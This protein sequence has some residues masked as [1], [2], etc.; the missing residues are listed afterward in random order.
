MACICTTTHPCHPVSWDWH[1]RRKAQSASSPS[2]DRSPIITTWYPFLIEWSRRH[3]VQCPSPGE[4][5]FLGALGG[6]GAQCPH[7]SITLF[8]PCGHSSFFAGPGVRA[9]CLRHTISVEGLR[10]KACVGFMLSL[11]LSP[12]ESG[13]PGETNVR[14]VAVLI[15]THRAA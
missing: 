2:L 1:A 8:Q 6:G 5:K 12:E 11:D 15:C 4:P 3:S 13:S 9:A 14:A 7:S 10:R